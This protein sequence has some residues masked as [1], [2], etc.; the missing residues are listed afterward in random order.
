MKPNCILWVFDSLRGDHISHTGYPRATTPTIDSLASEGVCFTNAFSQAFWTG[1]SAGS[2]LTSLYPLNHR[3]GFLYKS[4]D[5]VESVA[6]S[7]TN[8]GYNTGCITTAAAINEDYY[9]EFDDYVCLYGN[10][11]LSEAELAQRITSN[12]IDWIENNSEDPFFLIVWTDGTHHPYRVPNN[13]QRH[14]VEQDDFDPT[15]ENLKNHH[16]KQQVINSY[17]ENIRYNDSEFGKVIDYLKS[18]D[19]YDDTT[20]VVT[21]DH[22][23]LFEEHSRLEHINKYA[24]SVVSRVLPD[25]LLLKTSISEESNWVGHQSVI[26]FDE[27]LHIPLIF[28]FS[29]ESDIENLGQN[30][31]H[32]AQ[33]ID[34]APTLLDAHPDMKPESRFQGKSLRKSIENKEEVNQYVYS[35]TPLLMSPGIFHSIR[36]KHY[37]YIR[38]ELKD[39]T[40]MRKEFNSDKI[41]FLQNMFHYINSPKEILFD[42]DNGEVHNNIKHMNEKK[43]EFRRLFDQWE[44]KSEEYSFSMDS[45]TEEHL[46]DLGYLE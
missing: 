22:G 1:P 33:S 5:S 24:E 9:P 23:E 28:K 41:K 7:F 27:L 45:T 37:K 10:G 13:H 29:R 32:L 35:S 17:D 14:F 15:V 25:S 36:D 16:S 39:I 42:V 34:I 40:D 43:L 20:I 38:L 12:A 30:I 19:I 11:S 8:L 6:Q 18:N 46:K 4:N 44:Y 26:P 3:N 31:P 21:S 2:I